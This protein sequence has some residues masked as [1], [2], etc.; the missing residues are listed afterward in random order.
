MKK[1]KNAIAGS[2][3]SPKFKILVFV[4]IS[5]PEDEGIELIGDTW[6]ITENQLIFLKLINKEKESNMHAD[7]LISTVPWGN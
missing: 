6:R 2:I 5:S 1:E 3:S 4:V 7:F